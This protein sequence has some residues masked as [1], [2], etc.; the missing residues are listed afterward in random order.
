MVAVEHARAQASSAAA[1]HA[2]IVTW[3]PD[4][5]LLEAAI[6]ALSAQ[7]GCVVLVDNGSSHDGLDE[8]FGRMADNGCVVIREE[9][10]V[11]LA[12]G[13]NRGIAH[14]RGAGAGF[15][16]LMD[17]DSVVSHGAVAALLDAWSELSR[18]VSVAAVGMQF[19][20][21]RN[22]VTGAFVRIGFPFNGKITGA[23][24]ERVECDFLISSGSLIPLQVLDRVGD[25]DAALFIDNVDLDWSFRARAAG[26][27]LFG[28]CDATMQHSI[29]DALKPSRWVRGGAMIHSPTRLYYIMRNRV[30]LYRRSYT[31]AVWIAQDI[32]RLVGKFLRMT[33]QVS[34]RLR[35]AG[36][37]LQGL[38][39]G[40]VGRSGP[41][42]PGA[43]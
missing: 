40:L 26:M 12:A 38:A 30:L 32:P 25:M 41:R 42:P 9:R 19:Q 15:V 24:G 37:M 16:L 39:H 10:N 14:A 1:I 21:P 7:V 22:G 11:G 29:G 43:A 13:F 6:A 5:T 3:Q 20:D 35:N 8:F 31:P 27:R 17:Q 34:P 4:L 33:L 28:V 36:A 23:P 18:S 2:V